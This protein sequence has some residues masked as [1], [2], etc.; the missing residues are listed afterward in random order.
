ML[1][2]LFFLQSQV[3]LGLACSCLLLGYTAT[4]VKRGGLAYVAR[5]DG[6]NPSLSAD[7]LAAGADSL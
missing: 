7:A 4:K 2:L 3:T 5:E 6:L 1:F